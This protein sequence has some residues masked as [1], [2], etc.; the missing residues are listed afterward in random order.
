MKLSSLKFLCIAGALSLSASAAHGAKILVDHDDGLDNGIHDASVRNGGFEDPFTGSDE[1]FSNTTNWQNIGTGNQGANARRINI[2]DTGLYSSVNNTTDLI[3][4]GLDTEHTIGV[5]H[6]FTLEYRARNAF[7]ATADSTIT[8]ELF[9]TD[10]DLID[11]TATTFASLVATNMSQSFETF[12][13]TFAPIETGD[14]AV[15]KN[16]FLKFQQTAGPGFTRTD[17]WSLTVVPEPTSLL[18]GAIGLGGI[19]MRRRRK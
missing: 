5:G 8:A 14:A 1:P 13:A 11:G 6:E 15:G 10:T 12:N 9:Y 7:N 3:L 19:A 16:L 4:Y 18:V 2:N 17:S